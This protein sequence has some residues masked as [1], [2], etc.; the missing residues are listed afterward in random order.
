MPTDLEANLTD[1]GYAKVIIVLNPD[2]QLNAA[3]AAVTPLDAH[4]VIPDEIQ[5]ERLS[6]VAARAASTT[7]RRVRVAPKMR[8]YEKLGL[9]IG[10]I[11][12]RGRDFLEADSRVHRL[13]PAPEI[14]LVRPVAVKAVASAAQ[15][16]T[17]G[18]KR[19]RVP[20]LWAAGFT[21][22]GVL[23][24][25][26]DTGIDG[27]HPALR[28]AIDEFAEFNMMGDRVAGAKP[29][30][31][32]HSTP[33]HG[34]HTAGT[35]AG[36]PTAGGV[37][38]VA[39]DALLASGMVIEGGNVIDRILAG[40]EWV[41]AKKVRILSMSLGLRGYTPAF[42]VVVD[43][44]RKNNILPVIA[45]GNEGPL[46][47][48]SPGNYGNVLSVGAS[49]KTDIV[50]DFSGSQTFQRPGDPLV[51]DSVA[52]GV[53]VISCAPGKGYVQ[54]SGTSMATPHVAGLAALLAQ[55]RPNA[56]ADELEKAIFSS[57]RLPSDMLP[58]RGSR[59]I[60]D[61]VV[62]FTQLTGQPP[63]AIAAAASP[64][65]RKTSRSAART[66]RAKAAP[67]RRAAPKRKRAA[68]ARKAAGRKA[69]R[70]R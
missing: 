50:A 52:P 22:K 35:I 20:E 38:G 5:A 26:L 28:N 39:P 1:V 42:Q 65:R 37:I 51:P 58:E 14:S 45:V 40:M 2:A 44:L 29:T 13:V 11:D 70:S 17:W 18:I 7:P 10:Y 4:F 25:H 30:D 67:A 21:G 68:A 6:F 62:A 55:A 64:S 31:S 8:V 27:T 16:P 54:M 34:T 60:P 15:S 48:R 69:R 53:D 63:V 36:R 57:C 61:A 23:V 66:R 49:D 46:T 33:A 12:Q 9:A 43:A 24:G 56:T 47:S 41:A 32:D 19:L 3:G 59:G